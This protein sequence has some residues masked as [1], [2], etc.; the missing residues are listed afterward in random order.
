MPMTRMSAISGAMTMISRVVDLGQL[1]LAM[2]PV[3]VQRAV[4]DLHDAFE[5]VGAGEEQAEHGDRRIGRQQRT[6]APHHQEFGNKPL[7]PGRP[8]E[9]I[10]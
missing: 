10:E 8:R 9:A 3:F 4:Q 1:V 6:G 7:S 5:N 2:R